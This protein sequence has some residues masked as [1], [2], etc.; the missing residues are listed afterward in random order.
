MRQL[1]ALTGEEPFRTAMRRYLDAHR[2]GN[3]GWPELVEELDRV[4]PLDVPAWSR[5]WIEE[6][7]R[8]TVPSVL[9]EDIRCTPFLRCDVPAFQAALGMDGRAAERVFAEVRR[10]KDNF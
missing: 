2:F 4:T 8:P 9:D 7:G 5:V 3:A 6:A 1:E 10:M